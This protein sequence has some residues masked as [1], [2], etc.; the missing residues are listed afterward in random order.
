MIARIA[1]LFFSLAAF[2][3]QPVRVVIL[4]GETDTLYHHW[5]VNTPLLRSMLESTGRF[6]VKVIENV[7]GITSAT[8]ADFDAAVIH[9]NGPRWGA[10]TEKAIEDFVRSGHGLTT[11]HGVS[12]GEFFG[13]VFDK[14]WLA[15]PTGDRGWLAWP[16][17]IGAS[18]K[19]ENIGHA[20]R[21]VFTV[22][23]TAPSHPIARGLAPTFTISDELYHKMDL[24]PGVEVLAQAFNDAARGGTGKDEPVAWTLRYG[25]G[26]AFHTT[27]G[28]DASAMSAPGFAALF[29]RAVEWTATGSV[30]PRPEPPKPVRVLVVTGGHSYT[31][32]FYTV[33]EGWPDV[34]WTHAPSQK[35]AFRADL[36]KRWDAIVLYDMAE[37]LG[38]EERA[39]LRAYVEAGGGVVSLHHAIVDY[40]AWPWW[41][42]NVTGGKYFVKEMP[43]HPPSR[44]K[45]DVELA[46]YPAKGMASHPVLRNVPPLAV[47]DEAYKGMWH[48][49]GIKVL[50]ETESPDNDR[51]VVYIG[52]H[53]SARVVYIQLGHG[54]STHRHPGYRRLVYNAIQ[55][56]AR[57]TQ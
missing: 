21:H 39:S 45:D 28:H 36:A 7:R 3:Q 32:S 34:R 23:W 11:I 29:T 42:E 6:D 15:S 35:E 20:A 10:A 14:R 24:K 2:A 22:R 18:W 56:V 44:Y 33:F 50:M 9:Y 8:L 48:A 26:R 54:E 41:Y 27:L 25:Q 57:R 53:P 31:P 55:W 12:Y 37:D 13:Q 16:D 49:P 43:G 19:P 38:E 30:T 46:V 4:T 52:P 17:L 5:R 1:L 40:T 47:T 51:P